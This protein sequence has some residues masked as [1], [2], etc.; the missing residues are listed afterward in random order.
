MR[1]ALTGY[2][3]SLLSI[4]RWRRQAFSRVWLGDYE[5][6]HRHNVND[7]EAFTISFIGRQYADRFIRGRL[8]LPYYGQLVAGH[9]IV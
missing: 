1:I 9:P 7:S 8:Y 3:S 5:G 4:S 6:G 2:S